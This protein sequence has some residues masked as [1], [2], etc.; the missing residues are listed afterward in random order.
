MAARKWAAGRRELPKNWEQI[1]QA[2]FDRDGHRCTQV[3]PSGNRCP[4]SEGQLL[5]DGTRVK[6]ECDHVG[7]RSDHSMENLTS[8]CQTHHAKKTSQQ[9]VEGREYQRGP[10]RGEEAHPSDSPKRTKLPTAEL[11][12]AEFLSR[13]QGTV[14]TETFGRMAL[15][16][17]IAD[18]TGL[19]C[20]FVERG[21]V[22]FDG[23]TI[24][25]HKRNLSA[26][27]ARGGR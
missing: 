25:P 11:R 22:A 10:K 3:L 16:E 1:R 12:V 18:P 17:D 7:D 14:S 27:V 9:G 2:V 8:L 26:Y 15:G 20:L 6:L 23:E 21:L 19:L 24:T 5:S 13:S 4:R